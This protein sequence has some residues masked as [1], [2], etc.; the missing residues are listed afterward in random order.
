MR[1]KGILIVILIALTMCIAG[2]KVTNDTAKIISVSAKMAESYPTSGYTV[3]VCDD[4]TV[5]TWGDNYYGQLGNGKTEGRSSQI[6][7]AKVPG[8]DNVKAA[9]EGL[10]H[11]T[12]LKSDG[13]VWEWGLQYMGEDSEPYTEV[14][15]KPVPINGINGIT[16]IAEGDGHI[17]AL[18]ND[19]SVL[20]WGFNI[21]GQLGDGTY[22]DRLAPKTITNLNHVKAISAGKNHSLVLKDDGTVWAWGDNSK[23]QLGNGINSEKGIATPKQVQSLNNIIQIAS[24]SSFSA[25]LKSDGTIWVWGDV[26]YHASDS[27]NNK[28]NYSPIQISGVSDVTKIFALKNDVVAL[29]KDG[30]VWETTPSVLSTITN[31]ENVV[32]GDNQIEILKTDNTLWGYGNNTY[33]EVGNGTRIPQYDPVMISFS[34]NIKKQNS[35]TNEAIDTKEAVTNEQSNIPMPVKSNKIAI[36]GNTNENISWGGYVSADKDWVYFNSFSKLYKMKLDGSRKIKINNDCASCINVKGDYLYYLRDTGKASDET[37][38]EVMEIVK[39]KKDGSSRKVLLTG[40]VKNLLIVDNSMYFLD[41]AKYENGFLLS[42][43]DLN[44]NNRKS[45]VK[46]CDSIGPYS[47]LDGYIYYCAYRM[48]DIP[49]GGNVYRVK[50]DGS[51]KVMLNNELGHQIEAYGDKVYYLTGVSSS[52]DKNLC[53]MK[54]NGDH[55]ERINKKCVSFYNVYKNHIYYIDQENRLYRMNLDGTGNTKL[56]NE[57]VNG[58]INIVG[59]WIYVYDL[60]D[61]RGEGIINDVDLTPHGKVRLIRVKTDGS[62]IERLI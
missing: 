44:G 40:A 33:G 43:M 35:T 47:I 17:L 62:K 41:L 22:I 58:L 8:I 28:N 36:I 48:D 4:G 5:W 16:A 20:T 30:S 42:C 29:K 14:Q 31:L 51:D 34:D 11:T 24:G 23:G 38:A 37:E 39:V 15:L 27:V 6:V 56:F 18:K 19:G 61:L 3:A 54:Q 55:S 57:E 7:P 46:D 10:F 32:Q 9:T 12:A 2:F 25:A 50:L 49:A 13:T 26:N 21:D 60:S 45:I 53:S 1:N 59:D 52:E